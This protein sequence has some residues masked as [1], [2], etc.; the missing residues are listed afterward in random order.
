MAEQM[1]CNHQVD[2]S[3]PSVSSIT[4]LYGGCKHGRLLKCR[5]DA[6]VNRALYSLDG[7]NPSPPTIISKKYFSQNGIKTEFLHIIKHQ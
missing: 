1:I 5:W 2:G 7:S 3:N 6:T 4:L